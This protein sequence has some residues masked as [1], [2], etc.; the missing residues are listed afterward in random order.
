M[1]TNALQTM[2]LPV[3]AGLVL[4]TALGLVGL[5][6]LRAID[7]LAGAGRP[8]DVSRARA[9]GRWRPVV[10]EFS[11]GHGLAPGRRIEAG[12]ALGLRATAG[13]KAGGPT[14]LFYGPPRP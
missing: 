2:V 5:T 9:C 7:A 6:L 1:G 13:A 14:R 10:V 3:C 11:P 4:G 8:R 12:S